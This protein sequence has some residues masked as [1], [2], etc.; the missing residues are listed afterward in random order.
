MEGS[1]GAGGAR[2]EQRK[3]RK[4]KPHAALHRVKPDN[5]T[6]GVYFGGIN[7]DLRCFNNGIGAEERQSRR[8][9]GCFL[10][11]YAVF[12]CRRARRIAGTAEAGRSR[13]CRREIE[14]RCF[15]N[16][17]RINVNKNTPTTADRLRHS[18]ARRADGARLGR[19]GGS[20]L[21]RKRGG[22]LQAYAAQ[23]CAKASKI[24]PRTAVHAAI[25]GTLAEPDTA[26]S[27][28][29]HSPHR[30]TLRGNRRQIGASDTFFYIAIS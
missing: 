14:F 17:I 29:S 8:S 5:R 18:R 25:N 23:D 11:P 2:K 21:T 4:L 20:N 3:R 7:F 22:R 30:I 13:L 9:R 12:S 28:A 1:G 26:R 19:C 27:A 24:A 10:P 15:N 16:V 6:R